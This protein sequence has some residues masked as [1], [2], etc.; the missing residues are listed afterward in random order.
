MVE[1]PT[2]E[3]GEVWILSEEQKKTDRR[4]G[5][6]PS[7]KGNT[8]ITGV[9]SDEIG[10]GLLHWAFQER[11]VTDEEIVQRV[12]EFF[13]WHFS[14]GAIPTLEKLAMSLGYTRETLAAWERGGNGSNPVRQQT[15]QNAK[16]IL[17]SYDAELAVRGRLNPLVYIFRSKNYFGM[18][19]QVDHTLAPGNPLG[20]IHTPDEIARRINAEVPDDTDL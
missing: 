8:T 7:V 10:Q 11:A 5:G 16:E 9:E 4:K 13:E 15:I 18:R 6:L 12:R 19:D 3:E 2:L 20:D 17:A 14:S 1:A